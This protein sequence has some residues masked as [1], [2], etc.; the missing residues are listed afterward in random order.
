[1]SLDRRH[2]ILKKAHP[3]KDSGEQPTH[4]LPILSVPD[5]IKNGHIERERAVLRVPKGSKVPG[6]K[7]I[8][9]DR[10]IVETYT[11][12][13]AKDLVGMLALCDGDVNEALKLFNRQYDIK[14][15]VPVKYHAKKNAG[16][17][18]TVSTKAVLAI[19]AAAKALIESGQAET[20]EEAIQKLMA[21]STK[22]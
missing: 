11:R 9:L 6:T 13:K 12:L 19:K 3:D 15:Q 7:N 4:N 22:E 1:L 14:L 2:N 16:R 17:P 5:A 18:R 21:E 10:D 8:R 20:E